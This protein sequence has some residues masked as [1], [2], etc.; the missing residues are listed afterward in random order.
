MNYCKSKLWQALSMVLLCTTSAIVAQHNLVISHDTPI[1]RSCNRISKLDNL[2]IRNR[3]RVGGEGSFCRNLSVCGNASIAGELEAGIGRFG[4]LTVDGPTNLVG[5]VSIGCSGNPEGQTLTVC[6]DSIFAGD[7]DFRGDIT[8]DGCIN[9]SLC[10][11]GPTNL[12]GDVNIGCSGTPGVLTVC[13]PSSFEADVLIGCGSTDANL[14]VCGDTNLQGNVT[15]GCTLESSSLTICA[16]TTFTNDV[17]ITCPNNLTVCNETVLGNLTVEG[18][19]IIDGN[20][21]FTGDI[22]I[23]C[24]IPGGTFTVCDPAFFNNDVTV[25]GT[26][27]MCGSTRID[28]D[29]ALG[30]N[31]AGGCPVSLVTVCAPTVFDDS[32]TI[33]CPNTLSVCNETISGTLLVDEI[34]PFSGATTCFSGNVAV[35]DGQALLVNEIDPVDPADCTVADLDGCTHFGG[36]V[37]VD[38]LFTVNGPAGANPVI[39]AF[40][41]GR[42]FGQKSPVTPIGCAPVTVLTLD[43]T[44]IPDGAN[45]QL[46]V[47][48][49]DSFGQ[50]LS[51][52][53]NLFVASNTLTIIEENTAY[54]IPSPLSP[55]TLTATQTTVGTTIEVQL[56]VVCVGV[57][58]TTFDSN[59]TINHA[60]VVQASAC[61]NGG[62][63]TNTITPI[64]PD[65]T[66]DISGITT[67]TGNVVI[68]GLTTT[69]DLRIE[70]ETVATGVVFITDAGGATNLPVNALTRLTVNGNVQALNYLNLAGGMGSLSDERIKTNLKDLDPD[71]CLEIV[72][73]IK[74]CEFCFIPEIRETL[75]DNGCSHVGFIAQQL[76]AVDP[77]LVTVYGGQQIADLPLQNAHFVNQERLV[78]LLFGA[79]QALNK[80]VELLEQRLS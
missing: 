31:P 55:V 59:V 25:N 22:S 14:I 50:G 64:G 4:T 69:Q 15:I 75:H 80:K 62:I 21:D 54:E 33:N 47:F 57:T 7:V 60:L 36:N 63:L 3:L 27:T 51:Y 49:V 48:A 10:S 61:F 67:L 17:T 20:I 16:P 12:N 56:Q 35:T 76:K 6:A 65:C 13:E 9:G 53:G 34:D 77:L 29:I 79:I 40:G 23:G 58:T 24:T 45:I 26:T 8:I 44:Q 11:N 71:R 46:N 32:V 68:D 42:V 38:K 1:H 28:G 43:A 78:P 39:S 74:P 30:C 5:D 37:S 72:R 66:P 73:Q 41:Q 2:L 18:D 19:I 70:G 52:T